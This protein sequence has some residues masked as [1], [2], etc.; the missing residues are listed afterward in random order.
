MKIL[1]KI[2]FI[3]IIFFLLGRRKNLNNLNNKVIVSVYCL[4]YNHEKYIK[5]TLEGFVS[6][7]TYFKYEVIVHDDASTDRTKEIIEEYRV[8]YPEII[9]TIYQTDN[10]YSKGVNIS[11]DILFPLFSGKYIT[12]CEGDDYWCDQ[13]KLQKQVDFLEKNDDYSACVHNT[14]IFENNQNIGIT[15]NNKSFDCDLNVKDVMKCGSSEFHTS[16]IMYRKILMDKDN[17][18]KFVDIIPGVGDYPLAVYLALSGKIKYISNV[19][20]IY[21]KNTT[22]SWSVNVES[23]I[24]KNIKI[25]QNCIKML[26][27]ANEYSNYKYANEIEYAI[28]LHEF[29]IEKLENN[30]VINKRKYIKLCKG[31]KI[32]EKMKFLLVLFLPNFIKKNIKKMMIRNYEF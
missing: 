26:N 14:A 32:N 25:K 15:F 21:R 10:Q 13:Y 17:R 28:L 9:K 22:N 29:K 7:K 16:S 11:R 3:K 4:A 19:M 30:R 1:V 18:P 2:I 12:I 23:N 5:D 20:S 6:Q 31:K 8:K 24:K 27:M